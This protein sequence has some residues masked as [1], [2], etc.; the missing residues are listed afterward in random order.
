MKELFLKLNQI[1]KDARAAYFSGLINGNKHNPR[2]LF[3]TIN[4]L[5][6]TVKTL[7]FFGW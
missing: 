4:Q 3:G 7:I 1:I 2:S 5:L 6:M